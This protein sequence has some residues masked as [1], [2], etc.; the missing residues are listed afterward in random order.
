MQQLNSKPFDVL[1]NLGNNG[2]IQSLALS[3][4]VAAKCKIAGFQNPDFEITINSDKTTNI[5]NFLKQVIVYLK[6]IKTTT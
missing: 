1:I 2:Q 3:K 5:S 6:M 4:L